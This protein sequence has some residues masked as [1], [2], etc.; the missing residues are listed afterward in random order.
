MHLVS[1][2]TLLGSSTLQVYVQCLNTSSTIVATLAN[3]L[4]IG[5]VYNMS[6]KHQQ[7][8]KRLSQRTYSYLSLLAES[9]ANHLSESDFFYLLAE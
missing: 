7:R 1:L 5:R 9:N 6:Y 3:V 8:S 2:I 4:Y